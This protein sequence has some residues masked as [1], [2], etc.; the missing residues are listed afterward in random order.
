M[1]LIDSA[2]IDEADGYLTLGMFEE[3]WHF[4]EDLPPEW[5]TVPALLRV[6]M[7]AAMGMQKLEIAETL[8]IF[9][10]SDEAHQRIAGKVLHEL[11]VIHAGAGG[12]DKAR[13]LI[14]RAVTIHPEQ[15]AAI[16]DDPALDG[17]F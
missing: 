11:A 9:L 12:L 14:R 15:R 16:I 7:L 17:L 8:A 2:A 6:R 13:E 4:I 5:R 1:S 10:G 3:A